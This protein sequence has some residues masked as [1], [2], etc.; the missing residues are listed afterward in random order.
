[1]SKMSR[2]DVLKGGI[3]L[4][5]AAS[6]VGFPGIFGV[7][8]AFAADDVKTI[9]DV[10]A[11]AE[12]FACTHYYRALKEGKEISADIRTYLQAGL[13]AEYAHLQFLNANGA[14]AVKESFFFPQGTFSSRK[15]LGT[16]T[17]LA[18]TVF[19]A[20]YLAATRRF[21]ELNQTLLAATASQVAV[22]EGQ[23]LLFMRQLAGETPS[24]N[25][26]LGMPL[27]YE[28]SEAVGAVDPLLSGK[29]Q[30]G[31]L[32][33][34]KA[35]YKYPGA[36]EIMKAIGNVKLADVKPFTEMKPMMAATMAATKAK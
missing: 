19:V 26:A 36:D 21:A 34:E 29:G 30:L 22:V 9:I 3:T 5:A 15:V 35:E 32:N 7:R 25:I 11:T 6:V 31:G 8:S 12:T 20:A 2:R 23:H 18:E 4:A 14:K 13:A 17:A 24:N 33:M 27:F 16:V 1:M 28:V 10:A